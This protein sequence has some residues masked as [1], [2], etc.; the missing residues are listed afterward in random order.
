[1]PRIKLT[2]EYEGTAYNGWQKQN[3]G[4][5][6]QGEIEQALKTFCRQEI[7]L[8]GAGRTDAGVHALNQVAHCDVPDVDN[9]KLLN[10]I[11]G[12]VNKNIVVKKIE[13]CNADFHARY[14]A[15]T[16]LYKYII[17]KVPTAINRNFAW[18]ISYPLNI[19]LMQVAANRIKET[20]DFQSFCKAHSSN[21]TYDCI[22][23]KSAFFIK[24]DLL[25]YEIEA[26]RFLYGMVR[27][28]MGTLVRIGSGKLNPDDLSGIIHS[29]DRT[30]VPF[31]APA[32][33]LVLHNI[34]Y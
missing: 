27:A 15:K 23:Y 6:I 32:K 34:R 4:K 5:T 11:N 1:M 19:T 8:I 3:N 16:R 10:S 2:I 33:G 25:I 26:N 13:N 21:K 18:Y 7:S 9:R 17:S 31:T 12:L 20:R 29:K 14:D 24:D 30:Q 28:I 22:I